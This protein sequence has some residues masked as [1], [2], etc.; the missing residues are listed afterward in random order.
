MH[1][2]CSQSM[3]ETIKKFKREGM[4]IGNYSIP[5]NDIILQIIQELNNARDY[6]I[7]IKLEYSQIHATEETEEDQEIPHS[8]RL[9]LQVRQPT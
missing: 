6:Q 4:T 1:G 3:V 5:H 2:V 9:Q 7:Y 8:T